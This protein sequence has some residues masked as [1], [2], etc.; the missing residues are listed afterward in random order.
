MAWEQACSDLVEFG[1]QLAEKYTAEGAELEFEA[2]LSVFFSHGAKKRY[3]GRKVWPRTE[4]LVLGYEV[5]RSDSFN[6]LT[7]AM[8]EMFELI[9]DGDSDDA[10]QHILQLIKRV[11]AREVEPADLVISRSCKGKV[12]GDGSIDFTGVYTNPDGLPFVRAAKQ[13]IAAGLNF[14][15]GM[16][17]GWLVTNG[18]KSPMTIEAW[19]QEETGAEQMDYDPEFYAKRIAT[20]LGRISEA[21]GWSADDLLKGNRQAT[22]FSF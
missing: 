14:T 10:V 6:L 16:K 19:M 17:V 7:D 8:T 3:V 21:F 15:P 12:K 20:A 5:R 1:E 2:G 11:R 4:M 22:L 18:N 9:L 13:R